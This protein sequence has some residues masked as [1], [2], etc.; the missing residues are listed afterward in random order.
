MYITLSYYFICV[1]FLIN[2]FWSQSL[3]VNK[4]QKYDIEQHCRTPKLQNPNQNTSSY[5]ALELGPPAPARRWV[6]LRDSSIRRRVGSTLCT[7][8][9][10]LRNKRKEWK[11]K[12]VKHFRGAEHGEVD[13]SARFPSPTWRGSACPAPP[14]AQPHAPCFYIR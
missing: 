5:L 4:L 9:S 12:S 7:E 3:P 14:R 13:T 6:S 2:G 1:L 11:E 10:W 8:A